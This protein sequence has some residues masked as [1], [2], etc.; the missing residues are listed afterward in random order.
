MRISTRNANQPPT[1]ADNAAPTFVLAEGRAWLDVVSGCAV[2]GLAVLAGST[3]ETWWFWVLAGWALFVALVA[4]GAPMRR[5]R[6]E[7]VVETH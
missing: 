1:P 3:V 6:V 5:G 4:L 2:A 7:R